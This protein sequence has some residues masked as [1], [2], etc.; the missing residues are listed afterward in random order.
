MA[1]GIAVIFQ[2]ATSV[3]FVG[4]NKRKKSFVTVVAS[5]INENNF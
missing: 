4:L 2:Q 1:N 3:P 5:V